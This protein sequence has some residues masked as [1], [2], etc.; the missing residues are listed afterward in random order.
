MNAGVAG[1]PAGVLAVEVELDAVVEREDA[2]H[3]D[4]E[5]QLGEAGGDARVAAQRRLHEAV[6]RQV[7]LREHVRLQQRLVQALKNHSDSANLLREAQRR[8][9]VVDDD[10][11]EARAS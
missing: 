5:V 4:G 2:V 3:G 1:P 7:R 8:I 10:R 6:R 11:S 9:V